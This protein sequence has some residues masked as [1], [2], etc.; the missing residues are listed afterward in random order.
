MPGKD[1]QGDVVVHNF[2]KAGCC[3]VFNICMTDTVAPLQ[4]GMDPMTCLA[5]HKKEKKKTYLQHCLDRH[6]S[7]TTLVFWWMASSPLSA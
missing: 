2:W 5:K 4:R 6:R 7:F 3:A 1:L